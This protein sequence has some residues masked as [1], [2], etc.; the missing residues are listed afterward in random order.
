[1]QHNAIENP[2]QVLG[3]DEAASPE[4]IRRAYLEK[5][6]LYPPDQHPRQFEQLRDAFEAVKD[7]RR[8]AE[9]L[10]FSGSPRMPL[11]ELVQN[12]KAMFQFIGPKPWLDV[13]DPKSK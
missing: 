12:K 6:R 2:W 5:V 11:T 9:R 4:E 8:C 7:P 10:L 13:L 3:V 1:M